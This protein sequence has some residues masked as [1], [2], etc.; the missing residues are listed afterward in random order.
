MRLGGRCGTAC[1]SRCR[2]VRPHGSPA[3][4]WVP[5]APSGIEAAIARD[6][7]AA[8]QF[9]TALIQAEADARR[10]EHEAIL[11]QLHD[12]QSAREQTVR[13]A[14]AKSPIAYGAV[15]VSAIVLVGFAV[16]LWLIIREEVPTNQRDMVSGFGEGDSWEGEV[17]PSYRTILGSEGSRPVTALI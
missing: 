8:L 12:V 5:L 15:V 14:E 17:T 16:M 1:E 13:L 6:P 10:Q 2:P 9:K 3:T 11:A 7:N 4:S